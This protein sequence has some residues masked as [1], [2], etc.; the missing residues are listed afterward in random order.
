[1]RR[2]IEAIYHKQGGESESFLGKSYRRSEIVKEHSPMIPFYI[3]NVPNSIA[4]ITRRALLTFCLDN[5]ACIIKSGLFNCLGIVTMVLRLN[6]RIV[7]LELKCGAGS[8]LCARSFQGPTAMN[9]PPSFHC[10]KKKA[11][12]NGAAP[13]I[14]CAHVL[15]L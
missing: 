14:D 13:P 15:L 7:W 3:F 10:C 9:S 6:Y 11:A 8:P 1:M 4:Y 2:S 12:F 5:N